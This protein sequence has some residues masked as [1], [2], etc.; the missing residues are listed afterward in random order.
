MD[1]N[2]FIDELKKSKYVVVGAGI[3]NEFVFQGFDDAESAYKYASQYKNAVI[4]RRV[5]LSVCENQI[6]FKKVSDET[7]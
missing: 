5:R 1:A 7:D 3:V 4:A 6:S 2:Y